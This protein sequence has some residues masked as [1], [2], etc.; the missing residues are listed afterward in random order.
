MQ[1]LIILFFMLPW[2][3]YVPIAGGVA[4]LGQEVYSHEMEAE[5]A[6]GVAL[7]L[8]APDP[9]DLA[10]FDEEVHIGPAREVNVVGWINTD[11]NYTLTKRTNGVKTSE[12]YL[13]MVFGVGDDPAS[14]TVRAAIVFTA[15]ER[16]HFIDN[17]DDFIAAYQGD[18]PVFRFGGFA[19]TGESMSAMV[20]DAIAEQGL[21]KADDFFY[22]DPF[23]EGREVALA[24]QGAPESARKNFWAAALAIALLGLAKRMFGWGRKPSAASRAIDPRKAVQVQAPAG[25][26]K[27]MDY[28]YTFKARSR[29]VELSKDIAPDSPLG[30][31]AL[32]NAPPPVAAPEAAPTPKAQHTRAARLAD[33]ARKRFRKAVRRTIFGGGGLMLGAVTLALVL[34]GRGNSDLAALV[35]VL[36]IAALFVVLPLSVLIIAVRFMKMQSAIRAAGRMAPDT[37]PEE[38]EPVRAPKKPAQ[39]AAKRGRPVRF[40]FGLAAILAACGYLT[41]PGAQMVSLPVEGI[42][43]FAEPM[44]FYTLAGILMAMTILLRLRGGRRVAEAQARPHGAEPPLTADPAARIG[45]RLSGSRAWVKSG[46]RGKPA[47]PMAV[48]VDMCDRMKADPFDRFAEQARALR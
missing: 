43:P 41:G 16:D 39:V 44:V 9:V 10:L 33:V 28:D 30:R 4:Y 6:R 32:R 7:E 45:A 37:A 48:N 47:S 29:D 19:S 3:A 8:G 17:I 22:L 12:R 35:T 15:R 18:V 31:I 5:A 24:A 46:G 20:S 40:L 26:N 42:V 11:Y 14:R 21:R 2:W 1:R 13:Y 36:P 27:A 38:I 25:A 34:A 23:L